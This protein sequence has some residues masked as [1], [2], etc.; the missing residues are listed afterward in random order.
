MEDDGDGVGVLDTEGVALLLA[1]ALGEADGEALLLADELGE[2]DGE[3][4]LLEE[5]LALGVGVR[6]GVG[7]GVGFT[8]V[9]TD[10]VT[11]LLATGFV[12]PAGS[13]NEAALTLTVDDEFAPAGAVNVT[14]YEVPDPANPL[15]VPP[16][17]ARSAAAKSV[18]LSLNVIVIVVVPLGESVEEP[19]LIDTVGTTPSTMIALT[20]AMLLGAAGSVVASTL[21][22]ESEAPLTVK[23]LT[24]R[25]AL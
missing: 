18:E 17:T 20:S 16:V 11:V 15:N 25:S 9:P 12:L 6:D 10:T 7:V 1:D 23:L 4:L 2:A 13:V 3:A 19:A 22:A 24:V 21:P 5:G 14:V 8:P